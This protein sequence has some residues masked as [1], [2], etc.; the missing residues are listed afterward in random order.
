MVELSKHST[1]NRPPS[2]EVPDCNNST[3]NS[4]TQIKHKKLSYTSSNNNGSVI[5]LVGTVNDAPAIMLVDTGADGNFISNKF[6]KEY[7]LATQL[8]SY[9][10]SIE[11]ANGQVIDS[12]KEVI[13]TVNIGNHYE[14]LTFIVADIKHD[15]VLGVPWLAKH[16]DNLNVRWAQPAHVTMKDENGSVLHLPICHQARMKNNDE[17]ICSLTQLNEFI[18][19]NSDVEVYHIIVSMTSNGGSIEEGSTEKRNSGTSMN[20]TSTDDAKVSS[21]KTDGGVIDYNISSKEVS[22]GKELTI[23]QTNQVKKLLE[24]YKEVF[25]EDL[26]SE[27]PPERGVI[28]EIQLQ[29]N[30]VLPKIRPEYKKSVPELTW[31]KAEIDKYMEK[32]WIRHSTSPFG[33]RV[34]MVKKPGTSEFRVCIDYRD[35]NNIT[36]KNSFGM[37]RTDELFDRISGSK[38]FSKIDLRTGYYQIRVKEKDKYKTAFRTPYGHF[39]YNVMPMGLTNAPATFMTLMNK[40]LDPLVHKCAVHFIDDVLI[41]SKTFDQHLLDIESVLQILHSNQLYAKESKCEWVKHQVKFLGHIIGEQGI[42]MDPDKVRSIVGW[43]TPQTVHDVRS[44]MGLAGYYRKFVKN[45]SDMTTCLSELTKKNVKFIWTEQRQLTFEKLKQCI[46]SAPVL[47]SPHM[48]KA[49]VVETDASG[50]GV[51]AALMQDIGNGL[52]PVAFYSHTMDDAEKNMQFMNKNY[53]LLSK[54]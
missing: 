30:Y 41:Y 35:L 21:K 7:K 11:V 20:Q 33:A 43:P 36:V 28:H 22:I 1:Q 48:D 17:R 54:R 37:P 45:Y 50:Y 51:G 27:E 10:V 44:F 49:F 34:I 53:W 38:W 39:E 46:S 23:Q 25:P 15:V 12:N 29:D 14:T 4:V 32:N 26:P 40:V 6:V 8:S 42:A 52:Q 18:Q 31:L 16:Q 2:S 47:I 9:V 3:N 13:G 19:T 5:K 24:R